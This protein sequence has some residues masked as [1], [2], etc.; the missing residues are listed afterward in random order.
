MILFRLTYDTSYVHPSP[1][2]ERWLAIVEA[3]LRPV[4]E[5]VW[6]EMV[7]DLACYGR[8]QQSVEE[9]VRSAVR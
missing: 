3:R 4:V 1:E 5:Q 7:K 6:L 2:M 9:Y 8:L